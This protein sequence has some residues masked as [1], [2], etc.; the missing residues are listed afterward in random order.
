MNMCRAGQEVSPDANWRCG[1]RVP[2]ESGNT[3]E[4]EGDELPAQRSLNL[5]L[6]ELRHVEVS[7]WLATRVNG[8]QSP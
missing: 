4:A 7:H 5:G 8:S 2:G 3:P 6:P 1:L